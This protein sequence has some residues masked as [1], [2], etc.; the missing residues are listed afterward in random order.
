MENTSDGLGEGGP[1]P[2]ALRGTHLVAGF[3]NGTLT[4]YK[5]PVAFANKG[6]PS[7]SSNVTTSASSLP[8]DEW[9]VPHFASNAEEESEEE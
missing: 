2:L 3:A 8:S 7:L 5:L 6:N 1:L 4:R 9:H